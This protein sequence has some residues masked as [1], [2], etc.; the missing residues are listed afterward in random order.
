[1][2]LTLKYIFEENKRGSNRFLESLKKGDKDT[3][4]LYFSYAKQCNVNLFDYT[5]QTHKYNP[6]DSIIKYLNKE[7]ID[8]NNNECVVFLNKWFYYLKENGYSIL[9][10]KLINYN[11]RNIQYFGY[12]NNYRN[13][14]QLLD[15]IKPSIRNHINISEFILNFTTN[16]SVKNIK[17]ATQFINNMDER[18]FKNSNIALFI[19][20]MDETNIFE[21]KIL[22]INSYKLI[23]LKQENI[24]DFYKKITIELKKSKLNNKLQEHILYLADYD[25]DET[26]LYNLLQLEPNNFN[27]LNSLILSENLLNSDIKKNKQTCHTI[28]NKAT[29]F[30]Y[31]QSIMYYNDKIIDSKFKFN[32]TIDPFNYLL[33]ASHFSELPDIFLKY[34]KKK[35]DLEIFKKETLHDLDIKCHKQLFQSLFYKQKDNCFNLNTFDSEK[36]DYLIKNWISQDDIVNNFE[37]LKESYINDK[38]KDHGEGGYDTYF[39]QNAK[40]DKKILSILEVLPNNL[41]SD[42]L[43][44]LPISKKIN[45]L[46]SSEKLLHKYFDKCTFNVTN[47]ITIG[48]NSYDLEKNSL[49]IIIIHYLKINKNISLTSSIEN[50]IDAFINLNYKEN[51]FKPTPNLVQKFL[52]D[53]ELIT[54]TLNI[55]NNIKKRL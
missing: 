51:F 35:I 23:R 9:Q 11:N 32:G 40:I 5:T 38:L 53:L 50:K 13:Y 22:N 54:S 30:R 17:D 10:E 47:F 42:F 52:L 29:F 48:R 7:L 43:N 33:I 16:D 55:K 3:L 21:S 28:G 49:K 18:F 4:D 41:S 45:F 24:I 37:W 1:M 2:E 31:L 34:N 39:V 20:K 36:F 44:D 15:K 25:G 46:L 6:L 14:M 19:K 8:K 26:V 12:L 27:Q